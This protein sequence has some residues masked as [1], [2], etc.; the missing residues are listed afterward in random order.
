LRLRGWCEQKEFKIDAS[1]GSCRTVHPGTR[2]GWSSVSNSN[3]TQ[4]GRLVACICPYLHRGMRVV[5]VSQAMRVQALCLVACMHIWIQA[6]TILK[7]LWARLTRY[8][9]IDRICGAKRF[10]GPA[11]QIRAD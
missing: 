1:V 5:A 3:Y 6:F 2:G 11:H 9:Q 7:A 8:E 4:T 10:G